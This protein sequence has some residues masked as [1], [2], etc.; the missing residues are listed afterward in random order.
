MDPNT[1]V[2][3]TISVKLDGTAVP[4]LA[5]KWN[6]EDLHLGAHGAE[7]T[8]RPGEVVELT[9]EEPEDHPF[10]TLQLYSPYYPPF[11]SEQECETPGSDNFT[12]INNLKAFPIKFTL[13]K[14]VGCYPLYIRLVTGDCEVYKPQIMFAIIRIEDHSG[15]D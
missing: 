2:L 9:M 11:Q 3:K 13:V 7:L 10:G 5:Y 15:D 14:R 6:K 12:E 8:A 1:L 4:A